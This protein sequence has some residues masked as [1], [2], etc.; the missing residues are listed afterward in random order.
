MVEE[1]EPDPEFEA[2]LD[3]VDPNRC[4]KFN[5]YLDFFTL[6]SFTV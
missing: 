5:F 3:T 2:I 6:L 1:G 4:H